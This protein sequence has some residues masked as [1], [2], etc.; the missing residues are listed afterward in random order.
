VFRP[1]KR[2][3]RASLDTRHFFDFL[4]LLAAMA[5]DELFTPKINFNPSG[6]LA[7]DVTKNALSIHPNSSGEQ[8]LLLCYWMNRLILLRL[9]KGKGE[10][11]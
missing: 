1:E 10:L 11:T 6:P 8:I 5:L 2:P 3:D 9:L 7:A 4:V